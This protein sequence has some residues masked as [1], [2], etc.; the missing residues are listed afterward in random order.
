VAG[1]F[2]K[3]V[4]FEGFLSPKAGRRKSRL[5]ELLASGSAFVLYES[6]FRVLK[7]FV[8]LVELDSTRY[9]CV[10][11]EMT[12][13]H[14]EFLRGTVKEVASIIEQKMENG[15]LRGEFSVYVSGNAPECVSQPVIKSKVRHSTC[16]K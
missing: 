11:R 13:L 5:R 16:R 2:D 12:K 9:V 14:E 6:P 7:L 8:N 4:I 1:A 3:S 15:E 10:G